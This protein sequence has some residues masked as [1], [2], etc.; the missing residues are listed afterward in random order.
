MKSPT[1]ITCTLMAGLTTVVFAAENDNWTFDTSLYLFGAGMSGDVTV[2]GLTADLDVGFDDVMS[3]MEFGAMGNLR[4]AHG[5]WAL[6]LDV[7]YTGLGA[8]KGPVSAD[9]NQW[10][11]EPTLSYRVCRNFEPF[12]GVRYNNLNGEIRGPFGVNQ[13]GTQDWFDPLIGANLTCPL[14]E[15]VSL[16]ARAD[17]GGFGVGSDLTWQAFPYLD[18]QLS[19]RCSLQAGY[20]WVFNDYEHGSGANKFAYDVMTQGPQIGMTIRL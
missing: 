4:A 12:V 8:S 11:V 14:S 9:L 2:N 7:I 6:T 13:T 15:T 18:W 1:L 17:L 16:K 5:P 3:N 19:E 20:R 10:V